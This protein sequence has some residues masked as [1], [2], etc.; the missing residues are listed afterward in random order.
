MEIN[1]LVD[2][3]LKGHP[4]VSWLE[5]LAEQVLSAQDVGA[6]AEMGLVIAHQERVRQ[7]NKTYLEKDE[8]TDVLAFAMLPAGTELPFFA[9]P[10]DGFL[11]LGEVVISYPQAVEQAKE[12]QHSIRKELAILTIHGVLHLLGYEHDTLEAKRQMKARETE[13]LK[14]IEGGL[15]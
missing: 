12:H 4:E 3:G 8:P 11:H 5:R 1:V 9:I 2:T 6:N 14:H 10:P 7:L 13:I 15:D